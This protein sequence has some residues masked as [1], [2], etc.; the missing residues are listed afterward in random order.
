VFAG[1][2]STKNNRKKVPISQ[3]SEL[4][5]QKFTR[6]AVFQYCG[7]TH[8]HLGRSQKSISHKSE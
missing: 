4:S 1:E 2:A 6:L 8:W 5:N 7:S 3:I